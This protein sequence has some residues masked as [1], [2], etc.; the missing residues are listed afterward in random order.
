M[1]C[2]SATC[3]C[4]GIV[5]CWTGIE[6]TWSSERCP[7]TWQG[8]VTRPLKS[9]PT[10]NTPGFYEMKYI[11]LGWKNYTQGYAWIF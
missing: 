9:L 5:Q 3:G 10:P 6:T 4:P 2:G 11:L 1:L 7:S 8:G